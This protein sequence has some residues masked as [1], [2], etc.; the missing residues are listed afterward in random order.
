[1]EKAYEMAISKKEDWKSIP[2]TYNNLTDNRT[3][4]W[5]ITQDL[6]EIKKELENLVEMTDKLNQRIVGGLQQ[7][8]IKEWATIIQLVEDYSA[9]MEQKI[10]EVAE[11]F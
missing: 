11:F 6:T 5:A 8:S 3:M 9:T 7:K 2:P 10:K 1:M 4:E